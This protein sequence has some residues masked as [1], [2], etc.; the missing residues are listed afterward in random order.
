MFLGIRNFNIFIFSLFLTVI[1]ERIFR[2]ARKNANDE[3]TGFDKYEAKPTEERKEHATQDLKVISS[4]PCFTKQTRINAITEDAVE[5]L[6]KFQSWKPQGAPRPQSDVCID[7]TYANGVILSPIVK[8]H[9]GETEPE[10]IETFE[11]EDTVNSRNTTQAEKTGATTDAETG[12]DDYSNADIADVLDYDTLGTSYSNVDTR[13][14][15]EVSIESNVHVEEAS[16]DIATLL[17]ETELTVNGTLTLNLDYSDA[18]IVSALDKIEADEPTK[19]SIETTD[20]DSSTFP[21]QTY[22][23]MADETTE[24]SFSEC[25][26]ALGLSR[27][28]S[29]MSYLHKSKSYM[30]HSISFPDLTRS[31]LFLSDVSSTSLNYD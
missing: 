26:T 6:K 17:S 25:D 5:I 21:D 28:F 30:A 13:T 7:V 24:S 27:T 11:I 2:C 18:D 19:E 9:K 15:T 20:T 1:K 16:T 3:E 29:F 4:T 22:V 23:D 31:D 10:S 8:Y 12:I 14:T